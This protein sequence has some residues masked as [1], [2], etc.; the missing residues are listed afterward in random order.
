VVHPNSHRAAKINSGCVV[1]SYLEGS[2]A[3]LAATASN[4][5]VNAETLVVFIN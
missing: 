1:V 3:T 4:I 2:R 5:V